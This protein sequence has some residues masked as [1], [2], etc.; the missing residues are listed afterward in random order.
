MQSH[1]PIGLTLASITGALT[2]A[3]AYW[4][5]YC[6]IFLAIVSAEPP[7]VYNMAILD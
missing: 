5:N 7:I 6:G 1:Q 4:A 2:L 3:G